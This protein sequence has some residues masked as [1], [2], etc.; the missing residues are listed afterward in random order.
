MRDSARA[1]IRAKVKE[2]EEKT[3]NRTNLDSCFKNGLP[4]LINKL[5]T[6]DLSRSAMTEIR[7]KLKDAQIG[8]ALHVLAVTLIS[9]AA[10]QKLW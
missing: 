7:V 1:E 4:V 8:Y 3:R 10:P 2:V 5:E 9:K 6:L